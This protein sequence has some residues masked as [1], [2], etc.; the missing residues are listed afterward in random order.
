MDE[1]REVSSER[2][3][4]ERAENQDGERAAPTQHCAAAGERDR[5]LAAGGGEGGTPI[6]G[7]PEDSHC[8]TD[9]EA[10]AD[11]RI[12]EGGGE[13][14]AAGTGADD[15]A[16]TP[17]W[18]GGAQR[19]A[20]SGAA[21]AEVERTPGASDGGTPEPPTSGRRSE[22]P[23]PRRRLPLPRRTPLPPTP[24]D[25]SELLSASIDDL[26]AGASNIPLLLP[27]DVLRPAGL[28]AAA[29][30]SKPVRR[31]SADRDEDAP[32]MLFA[33]ATPTIAPVL[34]A[35]EAVTSTSEC[36]GRA[37]S[38]SGPKSRR[39][40]Q[41]PGETDRARAS[42]SSRAT[43]SEL[44]LAK[45]SGLDRAVLATPARRRSRIVTA[46]ALLASGI[47]GYGVLPGFDRPAAPQEVE[48][49]AWSPS[50]PAPGLRPAA[51]P[52]PEPESVA[53]SGAWPQAMAPVPG[54]AAE[55]ETSPKTPSKR[56]AQEGKTAPPP[57]AAIQG[58]GSAARP[59]AAA[60]VTA[61]PT[62][63]SGAP[64]AEDLQAASRQG[65][66]PAS[67]PPGEVIGGGAE[68]QTADRAGI[69]RAMASAAS[70]AAACGRDGGPRGS[71]RINVT[72]DPSGRASLVLIEP[73]PFVGTEVG[74]CVATRF[75]GV[76]VPPFGGEPVSV[77]APFEVW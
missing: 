34:R 70:A 39:R 16:L 41:R 43:A 29:K 30:G 62:R 25:A 22:D 55:I 11:E 2:P 46:V 26:L 69:V 50:S 63:P 28:P 3:E 76:T 49:V 66:S 57:T 24:L 64:R 13:V 35:T 60:E 48:G 44:P 52:P 8:R 36:A 27:P 71:G 15:E 37:P 33:P 4:V 18:L 10:P 21:S 73:G 1:R 72:F 12:I 23:L 59:R 53:R 56:R 17:P 7:S 31:A 75:R 54:P 61:A 65:S 19:E 32:A 68:Q 58:G 51:D 14:P 5:D 6:A 38:G 45:T 77:I 74:S 9:G 20:P 47:A 42:R 40:R 67:S